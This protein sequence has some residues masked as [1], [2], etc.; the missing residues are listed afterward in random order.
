VAGDVELIGLAAA[1]LD[2]GM[3]FIGFANASS[4]VLGAGEPVHQRWVDGIR[5]SP[6]G[7][8]LP[9]RRT[10]RELGPPPSST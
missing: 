4:R 6:T 10:M 1:R 5:A 3:M 7:R 8:P 9:P 2:V